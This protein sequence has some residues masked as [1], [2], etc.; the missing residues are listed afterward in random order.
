MSFWKKYP[1][2]IGSMAVIFIMASSLVWTRI[3]VEGYGAT[4]ES[5]PG[6]FHF[7]YLTPQTQISDLREWF[8]ENRG[9]A[10]FATPDQ[11]YSPD[12]SQPLP[13]VYPVYDGTSNADDFSQ[14]FPYL[15]EGAVPGLGRT[16]YSVDYGDG[17]FI[18]LRSDKMVQEQTAWLRQQ[19]TT[20]RKRHNVVLLDALTEQE[21]KLWNTMREL[22]VELVLVRG[23]V[24]AA[25][26]LVVQ[27]PSDFVE[28]PHEGFGRWT[29]GVS[30]AHSHLLMLDYGLSGMAVKAVEPNG[31]VLDQME[32]APVRLETA[33]SE[34]T[35]AVG[36]QQEWR[37]HRAEGR[38]KAV[39]PS[40]F[41]VTG[42]TPITSPFYLPPDDWRSPG[43]SDSDWKMGRA[44][45]GHT[46]RLEEESKFRTL[47]KGE[48][49]SPAYYFRKTFTLADNPADLKDLR[50][51]LSYEDG[52]IVYLNGEEIFRDGIRTGLILHS[53][54]AATNQAVWYLPVSLTNHLHKL[55]KGSN[56]LAVQVHRSHPGSPNFLFDLSLSH[57]K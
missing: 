37:F 44:P 56:T 46:N 27:E 41:D 29:P 31:Q 49:T 9:Q 48:S 39:I 24:F 36:I 54:L 11:Y 21:A 4:K 42:E 22:G 5:E 33:Q 18:F 53:S 28:S 52:I 2:W 35:V 7:G 34:E 13:S 6:L 17:R 12:P 51:K 38:I 26:S 50:M 30:L 8:A 55:R 3:P 32:L 1:L 16:V 45:F 20:N 57:L 40:S 15:P 14:S 43:F 47:L 10:V 25:E 23:D 19:V